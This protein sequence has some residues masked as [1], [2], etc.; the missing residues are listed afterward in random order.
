MGGGLLLGAAGAACVWVFPPLA[1]LPGLLLV[2]LLFFFRDPV[3]RRRGGGGEILSPADGRI[4][5]VIEVEDPD[6]IRG[7]AIRIGIFLSVFNV[8]V[9]RAPC[10]G[11]VSWIDRT[12]GRFHDARS[13]LAAT[14]NAHNR[15]GLSTRFGPVVVRQIAGAVARRIVC[16]CK[17]G[18]RLDRGQRFGMI[19]FGSRTELYLPMRDDLRVFAQEGR[20]VLGGV[21]VVAEYMRYAADR[22]LEPIRTAPE[23]ATGPESSKVGSEEEIV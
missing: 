6:F 2:M 18:D 10:K 23:A 8:H 12:E 3:R 1:V 17:V 4:T 19:K 20:K 14:E 15:I 22:P 5:D 9:N 7:R 11:V 16:A 21:T 13:P